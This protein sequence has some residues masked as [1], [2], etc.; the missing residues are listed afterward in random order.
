MGH[1]LKLLEKISERLVYSALVNRLDPNLDVNELQI[2][3][4]WVFGGMLLELDEDECNNLL[5]YILPSLKV[6]DLACGTGIFLL[7]ALEKLMLVY[8]LAMT[9]LSEGN[10][11]E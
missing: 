1:I 3:I 2:P 8:Q 10:A 9:R 5:R 11:R 4:H 7:T 6:V